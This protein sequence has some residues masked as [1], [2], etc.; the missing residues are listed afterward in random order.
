MT[1]HDR[2]DLERADD[3]G[4][5]LDD[6]VDAIAGHALGLLSGLLD[7]AR[8]TGPARCDR[9][10][11]R[12]CEAVDPGAPG[13]AVQPKTVDEDDG[14]ACWADDSSLLTRRWSPVY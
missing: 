13:V 11:P 1:D 7:R 10:V 6:D 8:V 3:P 9:R 14:G 2:F 12:F 5:V 4:V